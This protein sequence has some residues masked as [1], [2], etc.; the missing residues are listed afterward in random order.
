M[1]ASEYPITCLRWKPYLGTKPKNILSSVTADGKIDFWHS[2]TG[3]ILYTINEDNPIMCMDF[4]NDGTIFAIGGNDKVVKLY[5]DNTKCLIRKLKSMDF[6]YPGHSNRIFTVKFNQENDNILISGGWDNTLQVYDIREKNIVAS[7]YGPHICGDSIDIKGNNILT[8]SWSS[9]NQIQIFD[10]R[11]F[12]QKYSFDV[13][14]LNMANSKSSFLYSCQ[15]AKFRN[16]T[17]MFGISGSNE[18]F[19]GCYDM[20]NFN[21]RNT[22]NK[23]NNKNNNN[24]EIRTLMRS[25]NNLKSA[26]SLDFSYKDREFAIGSGD[27]TIHIIT[28]KEN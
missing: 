16:D 8:A 5:D 11:S 12:K 1:K 19:F 27:G 6:K 26:Y 9:T 28:Y 4:N 10:L 25:R 7:I 22:E 14:K 20:K 13:S 15:Y 23:N 2:L 21:E 18:N 24:N 3:K 17:K